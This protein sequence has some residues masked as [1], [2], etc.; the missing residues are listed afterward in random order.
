[1]KKKRD[2]SGKVSEILE[3]VLAIEPAKRREYLENSGFEQEILQEIESL[4]AFEEEAEAS[5]NLS[6]VE[7]SKDFFDDDEQNL[8]IGQQIGVYRIVRELGFGGM[9]A[10]YLAERSDG[11]FSQRVALK[12]LKREMNTAALRRRFQQEREILASLEH[13]FIA[14]LL[15]AGTTDDKIPYIAMEY[16]EGEPIDVFCDRQ[17]LDLN[18]RLDLFKKVCSAVDF[19][20]RNLIVHRDL[21]PSNILVSVDG[22]P[23]L[24]DFGISKILSAD[25]EKSNS[26]T[27]TKLGAMTP[28]YASPEQLQ[29]K[30]VTTA[31]DIYSLGV[32]LY[33]LLSGHRPFQQKE[34][35]LSEIYRAVIESEPPLPSEIIETSSRIFHE[36][37]RAETEVK[38]ENSKPENQTKQTKIPTD[39]SK[40]RQTSLPKN[41]I[42]SHA[43]KGDLDNIIFKALKKEPERRYS[44]AENFSEDIK[45]HQKGL[46]VAARPDTFSYRTS[47]FIKRNSLTVVAAGLV[48]L[49]IIGGVLAT[50]WQARQAQ[51]EAAKAQKINKFLQNVLNFSNPHWLSS[52]PERNRKATIGEAVDKAAE[53]IETELAGEPEI[54]GEIRLT[55]GMTYM[56]QGRSVDAEKQLRS[57]LENF[58][59]VFGAEDPRTMR[60]VIVLADSLLLQAKFEEA[61]N[62]YRKAINIFH[63]NETVLGEES[64]KWLAIALNNLGLIRKSKGNVNEAEKLFY[65]AL[66][67]AN[68]LSGLEAIVSTIV[69]SNIGI[70]NQDRGD[71]Q[72]ALQFHRQSL[73]GLEKISNEPTL[74][75]GMIIGNIGNVLKDSG[76]HSQA[77]TELE[78]SFEIITETAGEEHPFAAY[79]LIAWADVN[80]LQGNYE[81]ALEK[82]NKASQLQKKVLPADHPDFARSQIVLGKI[83]T[84][85][86]REKEGEDLLRKA[87]ETRKKGMGSEHPYTAEIK[88]YLGENLMFQERFREAREILSEALNTLRT[89][90]GENHPLTVKCREFIAKLPND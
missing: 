48:F 19:A 21:K 70:V 40:L 10:V 13:P 84:K 58:T 63:S 27:V 73:A 45:R 16:V 57:S 67:Y 68:K 47:K 18:Q 37:T 87:L 12:L 20:H 6:A 23:K 72:K 81:K 71:L 3:D 54:Q 15:D 22:T 62:L 14:R 69:L 2:T 60:A 17:S 44:S 36:K 89:T 7:F 34:D 35:N 61:E 78:K 74:E 83:Y 52:N 49:A 28:T 4:L 33:E 64:N 29:H 55:L 82:V 51:A 1:M 26:A 5:M 85:T 53:R 9:G 77:E 86:N 59:N 41:N 79:P 31:T 8:L 50:L 42:S 39:F 38:I 32:I 11:K 46:P 25:L 76:E 66:E 30:S 90:L 65:E 88:M 24:L 75:T 80:Y 43:L 56:G